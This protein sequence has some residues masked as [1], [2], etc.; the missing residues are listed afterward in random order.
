MS[1][2]LHVESGAPARLRWLGALAV[3]VSALLPF[4][5]S[6]SQPFHAWDDDVNFTL[7]EGFR[8]LDGEHL[9][10]MW[11]SFHAGHYMPLT[12]MSCALDYELSGLNPRMFH[13]TNLALHAAC[14]LFLFLALDELLARAGVARARVAAAA[15]GAAFF[16]AHPLR[17]ESVV[18]LTERRDVLCGAFLSLSAWTWLRAQRPD[19]RRARW[20]VLSA[21]AFAASLLSKVAGLGFPLVLLALDAW[22]LRRAE[23]T[24]W[25][26]L[27]AEKLPYILLALA[28]GALGVLG[29]QLGTEVLADLDTRPLSERVAI[30]AFAFRSYLRHT[31]LPLGLSPFYELPAQ[32]SLFE[33]RYLASLAFVLVTTGFLF[34]RRRKSS[35]A[36]ALWTAWWSFGVLVAPVIGLVHAGN[37]IAADRYTYLPSFAL[38]GLVA[39]CFARWTSALVLGAGAFG[40]AALGVTARATTAHWND[41]RTL[42]ERVLAVEPDNTLAHHKLGVLAHQAGESQRALELLD[43]AIELRPVGSRADVLYDRALARLRLARPDTIVDIELALDEQPAHDGA[44]RF[45]VQQAEARFGLS[46]SAVD[47]RLGSALSCAGP[48]PVAL[49]LASRRALEQGD[50][51]LALRRAEELIQRA[52]GTAVGHRLAGRAAL[53]LGRF[54]RAREAFARCCELAPSADAHYELGLA[55]ERLGQTE[56]ARAQF[57]RVIELDP[58]H[59]KAA[60]RL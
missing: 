2:A 37:Q 23:R 60:G 27:V 28:G 16:A 18:W 54:E 9:R 31:L 21:L 51:E 57:Q 53:F 33:P 26:P 40:I 5:S 14:A 10:W 34:L 11:T 41:T 35:A 50:N 45:F 24:G 36:A 6:L 19:A 30:S 42:F 13:A 32:L 44:L 7:N 43:R 1:Q 20:L 17:V 47:A 8:G 58:A 25:R 4:W 49:E 12:W 46:A 55:L 22:P 3:L 39:G 29:Q 56:A 15:L 38:A 48:P 52:P 59:T